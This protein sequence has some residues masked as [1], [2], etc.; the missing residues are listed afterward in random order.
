MTTNGADVPPNAHTEDSAATA[1]AADD[2]IEVP[3]W[4]R[5][6]YEWLDSNEHR[7]TMRRIVI[8]FGLGFFTLLVVGLVVV[9]LNQE[10]SLTVVLLWLAPLFLTLLLLVLAMIAYYTTKRRDFRIRSRL[11]LLRHDLEESEKALAENDEQLSL[12]NLWAV[13]QKRIEYYH[14]I[15]TTQS[16]SSFRN[17]AIA[18]GVGFLLLVVLGVVGILFASSVA[19]SI[20]IGAIGA[21][22]AAMAGYLGATFIRQQ[23]QA[24]TQLSEFF[25]QPVELLRMLGAER[26]IETLPEGERSNA[27]VLVIKAMMRPDAIR[28]VTTGT[29][30]AASSS[31]RSSARRGAGRPA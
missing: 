5:A 29:Q 18:S 25:A 10:D 31:P 23:A 2:S 13:T 1:R 22:G 28:P 11:G 19:A 14:Q 4:V 7:K 26:L 20:A 21:S 27:V 12:T 8:M 30:E 17:A 16:E 15:A 9:L 6:R 3:G 24:S